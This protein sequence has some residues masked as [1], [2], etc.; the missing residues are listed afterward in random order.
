LSQ[1]THLAD[2][3]TDGQT[4]FSQLVRAR[5]WTQALSL[6]ASNQQHNNY[7]WCNTN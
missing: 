6:L 7:T 5:S 3:Q 2:G 4:A 1:S